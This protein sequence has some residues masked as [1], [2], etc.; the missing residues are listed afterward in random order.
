MAEVLVVAGLVF[1]VTAAIVVFTILALTVKLAIKL[2]L[3]PLILLK[4][5]IVSLV[6]LIVSPI[7]FVLALLLFSI[8]LD[9]APH[10]DELH[11][12]LAAQHLLETGKVHPHPDQ[13]SHLRGRWYWTCQRLQPS[14]HLP[15]PVSL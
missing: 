1:A 10:P 6:M 14:Q 7:L 12:L 13:P 11:H 9:R 3:L 4:W 8:N 15:P 5:L 2:V